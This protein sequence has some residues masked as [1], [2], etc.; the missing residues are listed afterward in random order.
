[1]AELMFGKQVVLATDS[2]FLAT[3]LSHKVNGVKAQQERAL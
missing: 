3:N 1:M 2:T